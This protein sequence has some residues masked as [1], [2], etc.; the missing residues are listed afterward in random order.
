[1]NEALS[2]EIK[3]IENAI[4]RI[5]KEKPSLE[6]IADAFRGVLVSRAIIKAKISDRQG[7]PLPSPDPKKH[8]EGVPVLTQ[9]SLAALMDP[10]GETVAL[11]I[12]PM[13][14]AFPRIEA[15]LLHLKESL[16][17]GE[18]DLGQCMRALVKGDDDEINGIA[19]RLG[20]EPLVLRFLL[21]QM[22]KPFVE[23][24]V[25]PL[26]ALIRELPWY[27]GYCPICG[28]FPELTFL[29]GEGQR[30]LCCSLCGYEWQ[31]NRMLCPYCEAE[32]QKKKD[33]IFVEGRS[34]EF[35]ELCAN[36]RK[37]I[38]GIDLRESKGE[39][40]TPASAIGLV[41]LDLVAQEKGYSPVAMCAW[42]MVGPHD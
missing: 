6:P 25:E 7:P 37:Y 22:L 3:R 16:D 23:A 35:A 41:H 4:A 21:R 39:S 20:L 31:F 36:C 19:S 33:L 26:H 29:Q 30:W 18:A 42:N 11:T 27:R 10:W 5:E 9:E 38:V 13:A 1:M 14:K 2:S 28:S 40:I 17:K 15:E 12:A 24:R 32:G 8:F 34:H